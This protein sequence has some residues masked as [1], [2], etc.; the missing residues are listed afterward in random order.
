MDLVEQVHSFGLSIMHNFEPN[1]SSIFNYAKPRIFHLN[2]F[3]LKYACNCYR[4]RF[5]PVSL[6]RH[7]VLVLT[8][9][10]MG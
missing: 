9:L 5:F 4:Y 8:M 3:I 1:I 6:I 10:T 7:F 2:I